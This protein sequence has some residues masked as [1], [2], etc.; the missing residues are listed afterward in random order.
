MTMYVVEECCFWGLRAWTVQA[1]GMTF[2]VDSNGKNGSEFSSIYNCCRV[3]AA[4]SHKIWEIFAKILRF[5]EKQ[6]LT[7]KFSK[8]CSEMIHRD[9]DWRVVFK[10]REICPTGNRWSRTLFTCQKNKILPSSSALTSAQ[11]VPKICHGQPQTMYS[12]CSRFHPNQFTFGGVITEHVKCF[13]YS[14]EA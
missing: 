8:F 3:M 2:R 12:E 7:G 4:W 10:F 14:A 13:K 11:I 5:L 9:T 1:R 6:P